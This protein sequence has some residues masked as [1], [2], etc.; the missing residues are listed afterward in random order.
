MRSYYSHLCPSPAILRSSA[1]FPVFQDEK[2]QTRLLFLGYWLLK[3]NISEIQAQVTLREENGTLV[4]QSSLLI[5][6]AKAYQI[7]VSD[8]IKGSFSGSIEIEFFSEINLVFPYPAVTVNYYGNTFSTV[9][10]TAERTYNDAED[11][12]KNGE[13]HVPESGFNIYSD[14]NKTPFLTFINGKNPLPKQKVHL[15]FYNIHEEKL[16]GALDIAPFNPYES[17]TLFPANNFLLTDF[18]KGKPGCCKI[19]FTLNGVFPR[20]LVGNQI[21]DPFAQVITHSYYDCTDAKA[22]SNFWEPKDPNWHP[23]SLMLPFMTKEHFTTL[24]LYP[25][26]SPSPF[27]LDLEIYTSEGKLLASIKEILT[28]VDPFDEFR[29]LSLESLY[30]TTEELLAVRIIARPLTDVPIPARI[31]IALDIGLKNRGLPCNICTNLQLF[32]PAFL[33]KKTSFKWAPI[34]ADQ[35]KPYAFLMNSSPKIQLEEPA[36]VELTFYRTQDTQTL[37]RS[38]FIPPQG[39]YQIALDQDPELQAFFNHSIG[40]FTVITSNPYLTTYYFAESPSGIIGGDHGY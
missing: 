23:A 7:E 8:F 17:R 18:L 15:D 19:Q 11:E 31:K 39:F 12:K 13:T 3:R 6:E 10:H 30:Q 33:E 4:K 16:S 2:I 29:Q 27:A 34:L 14:A 36:S 9:V 1:I 25:I 38:L 28:I 22:P 5:K 40:W 24:S 21:K 35:P 32:V 37:K 26:Y 20:L